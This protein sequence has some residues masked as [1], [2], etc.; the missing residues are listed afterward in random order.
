A[1]VVGHV[2]RRGEEH[3]AELL[4]GA[5]LVV[6][7]S[8]P[9]DLVELGQRVGDA[10]VLR[11]QLQGVG[12]DVLVAAL[13]LRAERGVG[14][15]GLV[16][17]VV[18]AVLLDVAGHAEGA[19]GLHL[20][21]QPAT[22][23]LHVVLVDRPPMVQGVRGVEEVQVERGDVVA[24][25]RLGEPG[26]VPED[27]RALFLRHH[28]VLVREVHED[29][30][31]VEL[32][33]GAVG[34]VRPV[35]AGDRDVVVP[36]HPVHVDPVLRVDRV[37]DARVD[38]GAVGDRGVRTSYDHARDGPC[39]DQRCR[40]PSPGGPSGAVPWC[41]SQGVLLR[42]MGDPRASLRGDEAGSR[43]AASL[44][45]MSLSGPEKRPLSSGK[46]I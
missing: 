32:A 29:D 6:A 15:A 39:G 14:A 30:R 46:S 35:R 22:R 43:G 21:A 40:D 45:S 19:E 28:E 24:L 42:S 25:D 10:H 4:P 12:A 18:E 37:E 16:E 44:S 8:H 33:L 9:E 5:G 2:L 1:E 7:R 36:G 27:V 11:P 38:G 17:G 26:R 41:E 20:H 23:L 31:A 13:T 3:R 34:L